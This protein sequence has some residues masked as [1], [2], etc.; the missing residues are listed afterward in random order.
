MPLL[1]ADWDD[2]ARPFDQF[3]AR[4]EG[5]IAAAGCARIRGPEGFTPRRAGYGAEALGR[6]ECEVA[7]V[8]AI[9]QHGTRGGSAQGCFIMSMEERAGRRP[10]IPAFKAA[11]ERAPLQPP[12]GALESGDLDAIERVFWRVRPRA[13]TRS[14]APRCD[15]F[16]APARTRG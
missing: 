12:R 16:D 1:R 9:V 13:C 5:A 14:G 11:T 4:H 6:D 15:M 3:V 7:A 2:L 8:P 10:Q